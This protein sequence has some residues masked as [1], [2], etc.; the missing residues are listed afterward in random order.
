[1]YVQMS[2]SK[3]PAYQNLPSTSTAQCEDSMEK[4]PEA[5]GV[6]EAVL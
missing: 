2:K 4:I 3:S 6:Y 1:M 5:S